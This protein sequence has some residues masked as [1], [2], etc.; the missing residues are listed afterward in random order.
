MVEPLSSYF[1]I[2]IYVALAACYCFLVTRERI[3]EKIFRWQQKHIPHF[4]LIN[5][6][7]SFGRFMKVG[8]FF[9]F[10]LAVVAA[11]IWLV[12]LTFVK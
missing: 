3:V 10:F 8:H 1:L 4:T 12:Q 6:L 7:D 11:L 5:D 2:F 9:L